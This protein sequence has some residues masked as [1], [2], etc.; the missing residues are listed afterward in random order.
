MTLCIDKINGPT[1]QA[2]IYGTDAIEFCLDTPINFQ[3][4]STSN[5][6]SEIVNYY[7]NFGDGDVSYA[8]EPTHSYDQPGTY[9]VSL[10]VVNNCNCSDRYEFT[11]KIINKPNVT[12]NCPSVV[13]ENDDIQTYTVD[14]CGGSWQIEGGTVVGSTATSVDVIWNQVDALGFGYVSYRSECTCPFWTTVK[15]PVIKQSGTIQGEATLCVG[16]QG[17]YSLPQW[18]TTNF[19]W[20][21]TPTNGG[22]DLIFT[23]QRNQV[24][25]E[26]VAPG[27]YDLVCNYTNT[28]LGCTGSAAIRIQVVNGTVITSNQADEFCSSSGTKT[29]T[30]TSSAV[31]NWELIK[32]NATVATSS[33]ITFS[34]NFPQGGVYTLTATAAGGCSGEPKVINVTQTPA[35]PTGTIT[36]EIK[37]CTGVPYDYSFNNTVANTTL[38][39]EVL[40]AGS[41]TFQGD[42]TGNNV[43]IVFT[44][45]I[46]TVRVKRVGLD[47]L[48]CQSGWLNKAVSQIL[49]APAITSSSSIYCPSSQSTFT[50]NLNG[51]TPDLLE[52]SVIPANFGNVI[53][54]IN[55]STVTVSWNEISTNPQGTLRLRVKKCNLDQNF[56]TTINLYQPPTL[57]LNA[58]TQ[59]CYGSAL[60]L[61]LTAPG[62]TSGT[63][64]W[65]F[66]NGITQTTPFNAGG[67]YT[68][69]NPYNNTTGSNINQTIT[70]TLNSPNGCNYSPEAVDTVIVFPRT[71]I[72]I[73]PGYYYEVC[74]TSYP[75]FTLS[76][77]AVAGVGVTVGYQWFEGGTPIPGATGSTYTI[78]NATQ[79]TTPQGT[80]YVQATDSNGCVVNS[81]NIVVIAD[82]GTPPP[83]VISP[84]PNLTLS[85]GWNTCGTITATASYAGTPI[86]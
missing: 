8:F 21:L 19:V 47:G 58:P 3:N 43:T 41:G 46:T 38:V 45:A 24:Y 79:G 62:V 57:T 61:N 67:N 77:N 10:T 70:A 66:G 36:G 59:I 63:V 52:W 86:S 54:G 22:A 44:S 85:A 78:S 55:G 83:C 81:Q 29:Y 13:C 31:V 35:T 37:V 50:V 2:D 80:Y 18:P 40:P 39:W 64:T 11:V 84:A 69:N 6:G 28:L 65:D 1:A 34:Y 32:N 20:T 82:C 76:A 53:A 49:L 23:D 51:I 25:V 75:A 4:L 60:N 7:W 56:D 9:T 12:I 17:L 16:E 73:S 72:T 26:G 14:D 30:T 5:G 15:I 48:G 71:V 27:L 33:G 42:N 74:P 68:F